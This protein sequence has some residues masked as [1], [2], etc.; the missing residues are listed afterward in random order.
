MASWCSRSGSKRSDCA[1]SVAICSARRADGVGLPAGGVLG[2]QGKRGNLAKPRRK[3]TA[4]RLALMAAHVTECADRLRETIGGGSF[5]GPPLLLAFLGIADFDDLECK[6]AVKRRRRCF[7]LRREL[8]HGRQDR[9]E[10]RGI[11]AHDGRCTAALH[12]QT[13]LNRSAGQGLRR[14]QAH[15]RLDRVPAGRNAQAQ[16][17]ALTVDGFDFPGP[18]IGAG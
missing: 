3:N 5:G 14:A 17:K 13:G 1:R 18:R 6:Q 8:P 9:F 2:A 10:Y 7:D 11:D 4:E 15:R 12:C 16:I